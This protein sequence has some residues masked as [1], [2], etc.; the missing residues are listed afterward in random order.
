V[1]VLKWLADKIPFIILGFICSEVFHHF[2]LI[3]IDRKVSVGELLGFFLT[4]FLAYLVSSRWKTLQFGKESAKKLLVD[5][6]GE[7]RSEFKTVKA[8]AEWLALNGF[9]EEKS[10]SFLRGTKSLRNRIAEIDDITLA[11]FK[12]SWINDLK[13]EITSFRQLVTSA[14]RLPPSTYERIQ[15]QSIKLQRS[16]A[17]LQAKI[18]NAD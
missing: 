9:D 6:A 12:S 13:L 15:E 17:E 8:N 1:K 14:K 5:M 11:V 2:R 16:I 10:Q 4:I 3:K 18:F 7:F